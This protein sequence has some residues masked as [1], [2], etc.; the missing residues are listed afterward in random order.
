MCARYDGGRGGRVVLPGQRAAGRLALIQ[1]SQPR[2]ALGT[3]LS[4]LQVRYQTVSILFY[5]ST[6]QLESVF[7][8]STIRVAEFISD[9]Y[10]AYEHVQDPV[11]T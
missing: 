8:I 6:F 7:Y 1:H 3:T 2:G 4:I 10:L 5:V 9:P 11:P